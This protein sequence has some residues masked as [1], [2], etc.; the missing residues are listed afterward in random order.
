[1]VRQQQCWLSVLS[2]I[3]LL[4]VGFWLQGCGEAP[5]APETEKPETRAPSP[6]FVAP[7]QTTI[8]FRD[9]T[10][11]AG[12]AFHHEAGAKTGHKWY[13]ET[14]GSGGGFFDYNGDGQIDILLVN[15]RQWPGERQAPE[16]TMR[17]YRNEGDGTFRDVTEQSGLRVPLYGMGMSAADYDNDGDADL[18]ITGYQQTRLFRNDQGRFTDISEAAGL[19]QGDWST[20]AAFVD[21]DR[22]G[23]LDLLIGQYVAWTPDMEADLD[24]TYGIPQ[25]DYCA[26]KY[27]RGQG[28]R[29]YHNLGDGT[30]RDL[31]TEAGVT[32]PEAR[33]LGITIVDDNRDGWPDILVAADLTPNLFF[34]NR[35]NG[36]FR[37][38]GVQSGLVLDEGG[39][40]FAGMGIDAAYVNNDD[41]LCVA[42]GNFAGQPTTLHCHAQVGKTYQSDVFTE[43]SHRAGL[44]GPTLRMVTF[45]LFFVDADLDGWQDLFMVNGHVVNEERLRN[46]PY[47]QRPQLFRNA[48]NGTFTEVEPTT[49]NGLD[50]RLIGRGAAY[51]DYDGDGDLDLLLTAN[52]GR[53]YLLRNETERVGSFVR[54]LAR[55]TQ[56]N[57][58]GIGARVQLDYSTTPQRQTA[59][60]RTGGSYLS[61]SELAVTFGLRPQEQVDRLEIH[62]PSGLVDVIRP[63]PLNETIVAEEGA[64]TTEPSAGDKTAPATPH[65]FDN[66]LTPG[67][68]TVKRQALDHVQAGRTA[69]AIKAFESVLQR[70]PDDYI[71]QQYLIE[72]Y[73]RRGSRES[74]RQL[75]KSMSETLPDANF[76]LQFA[77][78]L[79]ATSLPELADEV[80]HVAARLDPQAPEAPYRL[81]KR[82]LEAKRYDDALRDFEQALQ[83]RPDL[84]DA[85]YGLSLVYA[86][87]GKTA[88]AEAALKQLIQDAPEMAEAHTH[89][90]AL[91]MRTGRIQAAVDA[92]RRATVLQPKEANAYHHLSTALAAQGHVAEAQAQLQQALRLNPADAP[93]HNDLGTLYAEQGDIDRAIASFQAAVQADA[94]AVEA[95]YNLAMAYGS[96]GDTARMIQALHDTLRLDP[97]H[98]EAHLNLGIGYLQQGESFAAMAQFQTLV[99]LAP[100]MADAHYFLAVAAAQMGQMETMQA[101][102]KRTL[103]LDPNHARA[104]SALAG[105]YFQQQ[106]YDLAWQHGSKAAEL[107]APVQELL[108]ALE[109]LRQKGG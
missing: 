77:F 93:A 40:A 100:E 4:M 54:V 22:D 97:Q 21:V 95:H 32:A 13:P 50:L 31:T 59:L 12:L 41:Q 103:Q 20:A 89:L 52:Q 75:L 14:M 37:E 57:R 10:T 29:L 73:W 84:L 28:L 38:I 2:G 87:Q 18:V 82:A 63:V 67:V 86:A 48:G 106:Q 8:R 81:G 27:F 9:V 71:A 51:A 98:R 66:T 70:A 104:H 35:G 1:V 7:A 39:I 26:V 76:L 49:E 47:A 33:V 88:Q 108:R 80:Y 44:A 69:D 53:A 107:G 42:I 60:V 64:S 30:F 92:Y 19:V 62:W 68:A 105:L 74:A 109:P 17:L 23:W 61:H 99:Q 72:L 46:V 34:L 101:S 85:R 91:Y 25:K 90:G 16:P 6:A 5:P 55:G 11:E 96:K 36:T 102:L 45:G 79:E 43:Q 65:P 15:G 24:C 56:S 94:R 58:D 78:N 3:V 83:R